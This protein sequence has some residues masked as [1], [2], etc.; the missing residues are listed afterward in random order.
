MTKSLDLCKIGLDIL[1]TT[2]FQWQLVFQLHT[3][4]VRVAH[5]L[6]ALP[7]KSFECRPIQGVR[8][9]V[10][11]SNSAGFHPNLDQRPVLCRI[12]DVDSENAISES[13]AQRESGEPAIHAQER[14]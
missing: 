9:K 7:V 4:C 8:E 12:F 1:E 2:R 6:R 11:I 14:G 5:V 10:K 13:V 3:R